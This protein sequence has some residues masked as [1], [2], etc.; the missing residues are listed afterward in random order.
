MWC[1]S[2]GS[3]EDRSGDKLSET[4]DVLGEDMEPKPPIPMAKIKPNPDDI[5]FGNEKENEGTKP[6]FTGGDYGPSGATGPTYPLCEPL[7]KEEKPK[8][9][10]RKIRIKA[11][12]SKR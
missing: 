12:K 7:P 4:F 9:K 10:K 11:H 6:I 5:P 8:T 2:R 3:K 1:G